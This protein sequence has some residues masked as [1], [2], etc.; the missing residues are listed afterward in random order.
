M[1]LVPMMAWLL[2]EI[3]N[4]GPAKFGSEAQRRAPNQPGFIG[5]KWGMCPGIISDL[6]R[7]YQANP[8]ERHR[9]SPVAVPHPTP[10]IVT[11]VTTL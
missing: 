1:A 11:A 10:E 5:C 2:A 7:S 3:R 6:P 4:R 9:A 8:K